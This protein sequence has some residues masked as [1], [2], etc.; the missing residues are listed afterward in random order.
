MD[1][2]NYHHLLNFWLVTREGSV[3]KASELLHVTPASVSIQIKQLERSLGVKLLQKQGRGLVPTALGV[4][5]AEYAN[6]IFSTGREL[7]E[8]LKGGA[9]GRVRELRVGIR[10]AMPKLV[11]FRLLQP[12]IELDPSLK[13]VCIESEMPKLVADLAIHKLDVILTDAPLDPLYKVQAYSHRLGDS[14]V[15]IMGTAELVKR[16]RRGFPNSLDGAPFLMQTSSNVL[17]RQ[18]DQWF[19]GLHLV[20]NIR[21]EFDDS[22]MMKIAARQGLGLFPTPECIRDEVANIYGLETLGVAEGVKDRFYAISTE[23][24]LKHPAV[25]AIREHTK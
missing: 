17:R 18:M 10:D 5:V 1:W 11:A 3:Q 8:W 14:G 9:T 23:R 25:L 24:K 20:P 21:G 6:E 7:V 13:L 12:A 4:E 15:V 22:A 2:L 16:H 19:G